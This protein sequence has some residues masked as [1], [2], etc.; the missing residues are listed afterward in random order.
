M[1]DY[2]FFTPYDEILFNSRVVHVSGPVGSELA[3]KIN[4]RLLALEIQDSKKP[5]YLYI[6][7]PGGEIISGF[8]IYD[9][10]RFI[11]P[12]VYTIVAGM[13]ASMGSIISLSAKKENRLAFPNAMILIHQPLISGRIVGSASDIEIHAKDILKTKEKINQLYSKETGR[14]IDQIKKATDRDNWMTAEEALDF[15]LLAKII[16][17]H[18]ELPK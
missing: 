4:Q 14:S 15:G 9:T 2:P 17:S 8:S 1:S 5:I 12:T 3:D 6:N 11:K 10:V 13:A 18:D 7:S 16:K